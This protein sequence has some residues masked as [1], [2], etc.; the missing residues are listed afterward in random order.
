[1]RAIQRKFDSAYPAA[2][3]FELQLRDKIKE[4][5]RAI[6]KETGCTVHGKSPST[7]GE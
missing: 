1:L 3:I 6:A 2:A 5:I 4:E 7:G